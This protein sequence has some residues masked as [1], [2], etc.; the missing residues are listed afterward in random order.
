[1][2]GFPDKFSPFYKAP[3][4]SA[5]SGG[6]S[7]TYGSAIRRLRRMSMREDNREPIWDRAGEV[8]SGF[9]AEQREPTTASKV[10]GYFY[11]KLQYHDS[12]DLGKRNKKQPQPRSM[13][14][15]E[16]EPEPIPRY[17]PPERPAKD[18]AKLPEE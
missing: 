18:G 7:R 15:L 8:P 1:M 5:I 11:K 9:A 14:I 6:I 17:L 3:P 12:V 16:K 2:P 4:G 13:S 10:M